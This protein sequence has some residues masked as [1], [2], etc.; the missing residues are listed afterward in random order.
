MHGM[1]EDAPHIEKR[2]PDKYHCSMYG[3]TFDREAY[4]IAG[5]CPVCG[6][7]DEAQER[8]NQQGLFG[9]L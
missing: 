5:G 3:G 6:S 1:P 2:G 8:R 4:E 9:A 7:M